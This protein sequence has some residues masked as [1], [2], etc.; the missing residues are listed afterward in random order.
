MSHYLKHPSSGEVVKAA[1]NFSWLWAFLFGPF[2]FGY[3]GL[4]GHALLYM[5][6]AFVTLGLSWFVYPFF[7]KHLVIR[8]Y[9]EMGWSVAQ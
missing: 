5:F 8:R 7:A 6:A 4:W 1:G 9:V 3:K 2:Y